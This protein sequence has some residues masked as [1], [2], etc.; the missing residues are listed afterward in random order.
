[1]DEKYTHTHTNAPEC[2]SIFVWCG[3]TVQTRHV[4]LFWKPLSHRMTI[5]V[6]TMI[7]PIEY[8]NAITSYNT[9]N[10]WLSMTC[11]FP[12][13]Q[14]LSKAEQQNEGD[15]NALDSW[16]ICRQHNGQSNQWSSPGWD[17]IH[18]FANSRPSLNWGPRNKPKQTTTNSSIPVFD[19]I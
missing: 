1:M 14:L 9:N 11:S 2:W 19:S 10:R 16:V 15:P 4:V 6:R 17:L 8:G 5:P 18:P 7:A 12:K 3:S 13:G